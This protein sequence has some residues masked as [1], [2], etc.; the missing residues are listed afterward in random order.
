MVGPKTYAI[1][2]RAGAML[3]KIPQGGITPDNINSLPVVK[4][5]EQNPF[6]PGPDLS[7]YAYFYNGCRHACTGRQ[8]ICTG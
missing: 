8:T 2:L 4:V 1:Q 5:Y 6:Y 7:T 3:P